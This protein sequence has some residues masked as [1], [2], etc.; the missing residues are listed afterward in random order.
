M[1]TLYI[2]EKTGNIQ[3]MT[4]ATV[5]ILGGANS[6]WR[7]ATE[8]E[9]AK[10]AKAVQ[11]QKPN[12]LPEKPKAPKVE[13]LTGGNAET[14]Q[15]GENAETQTNTGEGT[16]ENAENAA[17]DG[18]GGENG[19]ETPKVEAPKATAQTPPTAPKVETKKAMTAEEAAK[20]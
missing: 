20:Q 13:T 3:P 11:I 16:G 18:K 7:K 1:E 12:Y 17:S 6:G 9:I 5:A 14:G 10:E 15:T 2:H 4:E 19:G 8:E